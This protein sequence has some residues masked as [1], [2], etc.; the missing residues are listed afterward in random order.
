MF[1]IRQNIKLQ[2]KST[3][4]VWLSKLICANAHNVSDI[5]IDMSNIRVH[6]RNIRIHR[7]TNSN[8]Q[9]TYEFIDYI[10]ALHDARKVSK[11]EMC[12]FS[13]LHFYMCAGQVLHIHASSLMYHTHARARTTHLLNS[14]PHTHPG[15]F[16]LLFR[17]I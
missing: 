15:A 7:E 4:L 12:H 6:S 13:V 8:R 3:S 16:I 5:R 10:R 1:I 9:V 14:T 17:G 11:I 2:E